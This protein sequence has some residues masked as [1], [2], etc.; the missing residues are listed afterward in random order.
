[1]DAF[2]GRADEIRYLENVYAKRPVACAVC[3]R[4]HLGKTSIL[5]RFCADKRHI[6]ISGTPGLREDNLGEIAR[7]LSEFHGKPIS[8]DDVSDVFP[9]IKRVCAKR[10]VVVVIDRYSDLVENFPEF[11]SYLR[12][13]MNRDLSTTRIMLVVCDTDSSI[14]GRFYYT[15]D[16]RVMSYR[17][18]RGFHP[19]YTPEQH[20]LAYSVVGGTPAYQRM[21]TGDPETMIREKF[22][23]H[24][25]VFSLEVENMVNSEMALRSECVRVLSAMASGVENVRDI[26]S[27]TGLSASVCMRVLEEMEHK[28]MV[29]K[30]TSSGPS[31][32]AVYTISSNILRF[33]YEVVNRFTVDMEYRSAADAFERAR[34]EIN[35]Y[36]ERA[37][38]TLCMDTITLDYKYTFVGRVR[39]R[40]DSPDGM[41]DFVASLTEAGVNR[42][43]IAKC[44]LHGEPF[45]KGD[46]EALQARSKTIAGPNKLY[47]MFSGCGFTDELAGLA[48]SDGNVRLVSLEDMYGQ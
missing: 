41:V 22:F 3:G 44:R 20:L 31:K 1:M 6:Y 11:T 43:A 9:I 10:D 21:F 7:A 33:H 25:S 40:D 36:L 30:E 47:F 37:F 15:L 24:M 29:S 8:I 28:G 35:S 14:F 17:D 2:V 38:K 27:R 46:L 42:T 13:F 39:R 26:S 48:G 19:D 45:G 18:C 32:R 16:V 34:P 4:R 5:R 23:D 12:A